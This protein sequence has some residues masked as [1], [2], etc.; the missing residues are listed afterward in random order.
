[1]WL[2]INVSPLIEMKIMKKKNLLWIK[3]LVYFLYI[4]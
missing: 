3:Q 4:R 1:M 2:K